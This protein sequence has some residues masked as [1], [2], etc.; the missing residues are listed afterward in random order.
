MYKYSRHIVFAGLAS[1]LVSGTAQAANVDLELALL[2]D[3]SGSI[4]TS[5]FN[6]QKQ[7]YVN[8]FNSA[9][10][11]NAISSGTE[12]KIAVAM[13]Y[14][15]SAGQQQLAIDWTEVTI[16]SDFANLISATTRPF[17]NSTAPGSAIN[18]IVPTF[19]SNAFDAP[20]Q[21]IDVSGDGEQNAGAST[22]TARDNAL[23]AGIDTIN[24]IY[25]G[26]SA[27][28][29]WYNA[30]IKGGTNGFVLQ[31]TGFDTFGTAVQRKLT[32]E[33]SGNQIPLPLPAV[34]LLSGLGGLGVLRSTGRKAA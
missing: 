3:V 27:L 18:A 5:E 24:G 16:A 30:N 32:A 26:G 17:N 13:M 31:A 14:W 21:V 28:G 10:V 12:G 19:T 4:S 8:A 9:A 7:G 34:L 22:S 1:I 20:R 2:V 25:I 11:Q 6:T 29:D 23:L 33:I 15:S